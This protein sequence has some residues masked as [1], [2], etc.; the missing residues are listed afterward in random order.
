MPARVGENIKITFPYRE[1]VKLPD[2]LSK[3]VEA[4]EHKTTS[5][6]AMREGNSTVLVEHLSP[7][8]IH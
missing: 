6:L 8:I 5:D 7:V 4:F 2:N 1:R 3:T